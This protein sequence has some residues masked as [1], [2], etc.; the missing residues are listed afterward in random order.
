[1]KGSSKDKTSHLFNRY[2]WLVD[3]IHSNGAMSFEDINEKWIASGLNEEHE[4][5]PLRTFHNHRTAIAEMFDLDIACD[6]RNNNKYYIANADE[7]KGGG[8]RMWLLN[9]FSVSNLIQESRQ[10]RSRILFEDIPSGQKYLTSIIEAMRDQRSLTI[11]YQGFWREAPATFEVY[12]YCVKVFKQRWY[13][14]AYSPH[15]KQILIYALDRFQGLS[16]TNNIFQVPED[17]DGEIFF[18]DYFGIIVDDKTEAQ[19]VEIKVYHGQNN[20]LRALPLH[21]SQKEIESTDTYSIFSYY[22]K[23]S[24]DFRQELLSHGADIEVLS[25]EWFREEMAAQ[26]RGMDELYRSCGSLGCGIDAL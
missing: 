20:Y 8:L 24:Y 4:D 23:P 12:P 17:F 18:M 16:R 14:V 1:M 6:R 22:M 9:A 15:K 7:M 19:T 21:H 3:T 25:P 10:L 5:F 2:V 26:A 11:T 13:V